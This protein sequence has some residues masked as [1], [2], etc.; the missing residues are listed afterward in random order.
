M[1]HVTV[2]ASRP[3]AAGGWTGWWRRL[4]HRRRSNPR[5]GA[6]GPPP[7]ASGSRAGRPRRRGRA[8]QPSPSRPRTPSRPRR[9]GVGSGPIP[10]GSPRSGRWTRCQMATS[11]SWPRWRRSASA[12]RGRT[13]PPGQRRCGWCKRAT[14]SSCGRSA[15]GA[16][17][18]TGGCG[19]TPT[20]RSATS[21]TTPCAPAGR[22]RRH[23]G[24]GHRCLFGEVRR[25]PVRGA[26]ADRGGGRRDAAAGA[27]AVA[28]VA[29]ADAQLIPGCTRPAE[30]V[31]TQGAGRRSTALTR[32]LQP[33]PGRAGSG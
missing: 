3:G 24:G 19:P 31:R 33:E 1:R 14:R 11:G 32:R 6:G 5:P 12:S 29:P 23:C 13:A 16:A 10:P 20:A 8:P 15:A 7:L 4:L 28:T 18:G 25:Q 22:G 2:P 21:W 26:A 17:A 9:R 27:P 30:A